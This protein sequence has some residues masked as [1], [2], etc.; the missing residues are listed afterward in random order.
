MASFGCK[1]SA[2]DNISKLLFADSEFEGLCKDRRY[3]KLSLKTNLKFLNVTKVLC[4]NK[5]CT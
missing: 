3:K 1:Q 4:M 2:E 5:I